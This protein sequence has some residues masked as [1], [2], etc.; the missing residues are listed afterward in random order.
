MDKEDIHK[1][2]EAYQSLFK[3]IN[4]LYRNIAKAYGLSECAFWVL[5]TL[6]TDRREWTQSELS[7]TLCQPKQ[8]INSAFKQL[9]AKG[10]L[11]FGHDNGRRNKPVRLTEVGN[12]FVERTIDK[13]FDAEISAL[14]GM[15]DSDWQ[16]FW[17]LFD[18][19]T[20]LLKGCVKKLILNQEEKNE[21]CNNQP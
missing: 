7:D 8:T 10:Y 3:E 6:R 12:A 5:Y 18:A 14:S 9:R 15:K 4:R 19:H 20:N 13:V 16:T 1:Q 21:Y 2:V 11:I 17:K